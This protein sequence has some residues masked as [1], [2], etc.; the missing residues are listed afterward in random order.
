MLEKLK[1]ETENKKGFSPFST[2]KEKWALYFN[3]QTDIALEIQ[4]DTYKCNVFGR[5]GH[6]IYE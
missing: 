4:I 6:V 2:T 1:T 5:K 3:D